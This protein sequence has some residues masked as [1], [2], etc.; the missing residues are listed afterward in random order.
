MR[1]A[2]A[3]RAHLDI[4]FGWFGELVGRWGE[5]DGLAERF[6]SGDEAP[7]FTLRVDASDEVVAAEFLVVDVFADDVVGDVKDG[8]RDR[9]EGPCLATPTGDVPELC[10]EVAV[11]GMT[12][13]PRALA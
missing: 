4:R 5:V 6:E 1:R 13:G 10:G 9:G 11:A 12:R 2:P 7:R 8:M 3:G